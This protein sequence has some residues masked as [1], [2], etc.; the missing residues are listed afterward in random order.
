MPPK[1]SA[2]FLGQFVVDIGGQLAK[3]VQTTSFTVLVRVFS[4]HEPVS[5]G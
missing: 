3:D 4:A 2:D 5:G 1:L